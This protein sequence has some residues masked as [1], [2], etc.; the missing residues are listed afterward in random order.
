MTTEIL[1]FAQVCFYTSRAFTVFSCV[2]LAG[3][4]VDILLDNF[5]EV[6]IFII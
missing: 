2:Y 1:S 4:R 5:V 3:E 6:P